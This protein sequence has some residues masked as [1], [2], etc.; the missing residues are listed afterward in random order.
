MSRV[1]RLSRLLAALHELPVA[2]R[3]HM[4][5]IL[6]VVGLH[7]VRDA[8]ATA[9]VEHGLAVLALLAH[10]LVVLLLLLFQLVVECMELG[11]LV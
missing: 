1:D 6:L 3:V 11:A 9:R 5:H 4:L 7:E 2:V 10:H 8:A